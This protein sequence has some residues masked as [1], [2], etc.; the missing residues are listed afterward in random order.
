MVKSG[1]PML[2]SPPLDLRFNSV[3]T[4]KIATVTYMKQ[5]EDELTINVGDSGMLY[6]C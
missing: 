5:L 3:I 2:E 1:S 4:P 6:S